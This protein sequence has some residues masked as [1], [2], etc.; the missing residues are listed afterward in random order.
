MSSAYFDYKASE[1][2]ANPQRRNVALRVAQAI[3]EAIPIHRGMSALEFGC[4]TGL[5]SRALL[6]DV[7][8]ITA[9]D[10]SSGM[11]DEL[12]Q[13]IEKEK[14]SRITARCLNLLTARFSVPFDLIYSALALHHVS[15]LDAHFDELTR[16]VMP[17]GY[18]HSPISTQ[19]MDLFTEK[20]STRFI[21]GLIAA[22]G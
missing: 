13:R 2:D 9:V 19:R 7:G 12:K 17:T 21:E 4:G 8:Q 6:S 22:Y 20:S 5:I 14:L 15:N 3:R 11:I 18:M 10:L 1:W 16:L